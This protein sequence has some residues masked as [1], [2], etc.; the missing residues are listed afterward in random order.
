MTP[1]FGVIPP[2]PFRRIGKFGGYVAAPGN[3]EFVLQFAPITPS[4]AV[5][6]SAEYPYCI[7]SSNRSVTGLCPVASPSRVTVDVPGTPLAKNSS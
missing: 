4:T 2:A 5:P 6:W 1:I 7:F 3:G